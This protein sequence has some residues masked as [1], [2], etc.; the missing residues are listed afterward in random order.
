MSAKTTRPAGCDRERSTLLH[1]RSGLWARPRPTLLPI[2]GPRRRGPGRIDGIRG[3]GTLLFGVRS[4]PTG[5]PR[6]EIT[7]E[8]LRRHL[9][10]RIAV[11][12][13]EPGVAEG[14]GG[15]LRNLAVPGC[16]FLLK[17]E[18]KQ[19]GRLQR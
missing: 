6:D 1:S 3:H 16:A 8:P 14:L 10:E 15:T 2:F 13:A 11:P 7:E 9:C 19:R 18:R 12:R 4:S 5:F 17:H